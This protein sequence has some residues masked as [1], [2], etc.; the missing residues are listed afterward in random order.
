MS[1]TPPEVRAQTVSEAWLRAV[2]V[3]NGFSNKRSACHLVVRVERPAE[4]VGRIRQLADRLLDDLALPLIDT[5]RNTIFPATTA[6]RFPEPGD[7][8]THYRLHYPVHRRF[9]KRGTYFGRLVALPDGKG[10]EIDQLSHVVDKLREGSKLSSRY[11]MNIYLA[12]EDRKVRLGF[13]CMS[14]CAI[15]REH[16]VLHLAATYRNQYLIERGYGNYLAL[17]QLLQY[18]ARATDHH[19]GELL[20]LAGHAEVD[21]ASRRKVSDLLAAAGGRR[22]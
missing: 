18:V 1:A 2:E 14:N 6:E 3:V 11:E 10:G 7:L 12:Q 21:R 16:G 5:V 4:E 8:A 13:P 9:N 17:G 19:A 20:I 15:H 22:G